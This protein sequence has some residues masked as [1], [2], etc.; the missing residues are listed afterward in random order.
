MC[1]PEENA[2]LIREKEALEA[3]LAAPVRQVHHGA[4]PHHRA[5]FLDL[6]AE[7]LDIPAVATDVGFITS[8]RNSL[9]LS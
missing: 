8:R 4:F 2:A 1:W 5:G 3:A 9:T 6:S 7:R